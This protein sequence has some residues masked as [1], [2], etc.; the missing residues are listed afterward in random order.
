M[1][2]IN[3]PSA[4]QINDD[5]L[6]YMADTLKWIP[7]YNPAKAEKSEGLCW[8]GPTVIKSEGAKVTA[9]IFRAWA[10]LLSCGPKRLRLTGSWG[11]KEGN[12]VA[13]GEYEKIKLDRD[14][15]VI[16]ITALATL[17]DRVAESKDELYILH[18]GI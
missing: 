8:C 14:E 18:L 3:A 4:I 2:F 15:A 12:P 17:A 5:L 10:E 6:G 13:E 11:V 9:R 16:M 7:T 1:N